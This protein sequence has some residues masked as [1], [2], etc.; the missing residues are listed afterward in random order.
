MPQ[1]LGIHWIIDYVEVLFRK[2]II[3]PDD[4]ESYSSVEV[5]V[6]KENLWAFDNFSS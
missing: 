3:V 4:N 1:A 2:T 6:W 5:N